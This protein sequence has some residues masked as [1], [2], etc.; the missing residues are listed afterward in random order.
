[1]KNIN[2]KIRKAEEIPPVPPAGHKTIKEQIKD[3][4]PEAHQPLADKPKEI[5]MNKYGIQE[6]K[7][8]V[9]TLT[10]IAN[11][12][13]NA[14]KDGKVS[15]LELPSFIV[16]LTKLPAAFSGISQVPN[17][18]NDLNEEEKADLIRFIAEELDVDANAE[19]I[20]SLALSVAY[21]IKK[22]IDQFKI[23]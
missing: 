23:K 22:L 1:M 15:L 20:V 2:P 4:A 10:S 13:S 17:E 3:Y 9:I 11:A 16:P 12:A 5:K 6:T 19:A 8:V 7:D 21:E 14:L 18:L